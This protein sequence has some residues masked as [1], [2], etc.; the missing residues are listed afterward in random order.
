[1]NYASG[2]KYAIIKAERN[3]I[4][5]RNTSLCYIEH[6]GCYLMLHRTKK[7]VDENSG[8]W[9]GVGGGFEEGESPEDCCIREVREETGYTVLPE[10]IRPFGEIEEKRQSRHEPMIW[11]QYSRLY[12]CDVAPEQGNCEFTANEKKY[13]FHRVMYTLEEALEKNRRMTAGEGEK[14]WNQREYR[15][16][17]I[18]KEYL[19]SNEA[20]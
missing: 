2:K 6:N 14:P 10:S 16:L 11:H 20:E 5:L 12:F 15:T 4:D 19:E 7:A 18:L 3:V 8:K 17:R 9:I 1:M 13:G